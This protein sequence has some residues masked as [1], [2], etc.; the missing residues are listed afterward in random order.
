MLSVPLR[1]YWAKAMSSRM[2]VK[3]EHVARSPKGSRTRVERLLQKVGRHRVAIRENRGYAASFWR[4]VSC[5]GGKPARFSCWP[6][7]AL[8]R[9]TTGLSRRTNR[10]L[11]DCSICSQAGSLTTGQRLCK[12]CMPSARDISSS[13]AQVSWRSLWMTF[14]LRASRFGRFSEVH[15]DALPETERGARDSTQWRAEQRKHAS[16]GN[17]HEGQCSGTPGN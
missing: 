14:L 4:I 5:Y 10:F 9:S 12:G 2:A 8:R 17:K 6:V 3:Q 16:C 1:R 7:S 15:S 13:T 11:C